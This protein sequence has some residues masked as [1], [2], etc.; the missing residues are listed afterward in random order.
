M[1]LETELASRTLRFDGIS[2]VD[3]D[4]VSE[5]FLR[6]I[7]PSELR[8]RVKTP[9]VEAFNKLVCQEDQLLEAANEPIK[10][11]FDWQVPKELL[12]ADL[13]T[14]VSEAFGEKLPKLKYSD[15]ELAAA[16]E[17]LDFE[18]Q[19]IKAHGMEQFFKT[20][21]FIIQT[22]KANNVVWG[23]GRGSSCASYVLFILGLHVVDCIKFN[24]PASEFFHD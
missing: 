4:K 1:R 22:F 24:V 14:I 8:V 3:A 7:R 6:G 12:E 11:Q 2:V 16:I 17:R 5:A 9:E 23:V 18:V 13:S 21:V 10:I 20:V 19:E 15:E